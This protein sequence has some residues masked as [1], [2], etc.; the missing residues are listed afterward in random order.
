ML[1]F[2]HWIYLINHSI[3]H[4]TGFRLRN[5]S[6]AYSSIIRDFKGRVDM[7]RG[8]QTNGSW[9]HVCADGL[10]Q[11]EADMICRQH[12]HRYKNKIQ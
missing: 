11:A 10:G 7:Y 6:D 4:F 3:A 5:E 8:N 12:R 1:I 9:Y 2:K